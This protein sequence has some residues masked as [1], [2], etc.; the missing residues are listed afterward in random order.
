MCRL[1]LSSRIF[2]GK[3]TN[4]QTSSSDFLFFQRKKRKRA[5][6]KTCF[7]IN[8]E[9]TG[10][11]APTITSTD[12]VLK[13]LGYRIDRNLGNITA[14]F[15]KDHHLANTGAELH[16]SNTGILDSLRHRKF[17]RMVYMLGK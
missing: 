10:L 5:G 3:N 11:V 12:S 7:S 8:I 17:A 9:P 16:S 6:R 2:A 1:V 4:Q 15:R 13:L 14:R